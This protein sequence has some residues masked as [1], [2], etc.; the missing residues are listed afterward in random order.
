MLGSAPYAI[1][2]ALYLAM[3]TN[4]L[5][6]PL[7]VAAPRMSMTEMLLAWPRLLMF[8]AAHLLWPVHLSLCYNLP[9]SAALWPL[10]LLIAAAASLLWTLP[11]ASPAVRY[12][13]AWFFIT[14]LP[15]LAI[16]YIDASGFV[17]DRY[18]YLPL[19]GL[20]LAGAPV[21][22][23]L[24]LTAPRVILL[25]ALTTAMMWGMYVNQQLWRDNVTLLSR[26]VQTDPQS[27]FMQS[28]LADAF[29]Q[30]R[31]PA[32]ALPLALNLMRDHPELPDG[33]LHMAAYCQQVGQ[34]EMAR[35]YY[36]MAMALQVGKP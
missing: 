19:V 17:H 33:F 29:L 32:D 20:V 9:Q 10:L 16:R 4:A 25:A 26:A 11:K 30:A 21:M 27:A 24:R 7:I 34:P 8:Y 3:R 14:L 31:R 1:I 15:S 22:S 6:N 2:A 18:L 35:R 12:G 13:L 28:D 23:R 36:S 5:G